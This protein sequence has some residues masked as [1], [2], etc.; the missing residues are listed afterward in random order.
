MREIIRNRAIVQDTYA[1]VTDGAAAPAGADLLVPLDRFLDDPETFL[2]GEGRLGVE[3]G[4]DDDFEAVLAYRDRL[5]LIALRFPKFSDSRGYTTARLLR[6]AGW[7]GELRATGDVLPDQVFY[8][9]RCG[10]DAFD[11]REDKRLDTALRAL[12]T[13][14]VTYQG[15]ETDLPLYRRRFASGRARAS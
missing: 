1:R 14:S 9:H 11:V 6:R 12:D 13:F 10:F 8:L 5:S 4:P 15:A 3:L 7:E 2:V